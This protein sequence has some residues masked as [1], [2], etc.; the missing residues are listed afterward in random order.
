M[1]TGWRMGKAIADRCN[2]AISTRSFLP[3]RTSQ[4]PLRPATRCVS[5]LIG[6]RQF[7]R[8]SNPKRKRGNELCTIPR[9]RFGLQK[10]SVSAKTGAVQLRSC[11][12][13]LRHHFLF[14]LAIFRSRFALRRKSFPAERTYHSVYLPLARHGACFLFQHGLDLIHII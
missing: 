9:S 2:L 11:C 13:R 6:Q 8:S 10:H 5:T 14:R 4:P 7:F 3:E 1:N 12:R